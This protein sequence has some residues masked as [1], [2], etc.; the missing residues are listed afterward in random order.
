MKKTA[1]FVALL[2][3]SAC[4][5]NHTF[6]A[7]PQQ[8]RAKNSEQQITITG[9]VDQE[10]KRNVLK[11][12]LSSDVTIFFNGT[13]HIT[14]RLDQQGFGEFNGQ[15][16]NDLPTSASCSSKHIT[17]NTGELRCIVFINGERAATLTM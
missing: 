1:L 16:Y 13:P 12:S 2:S 7:A 11:N 14:G 9:K 4:A 15:P 6:T 3:L 10:L 8:Y 5:T 17:Q